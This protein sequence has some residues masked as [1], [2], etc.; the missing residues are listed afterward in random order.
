MCFLFQLFV[1]LIVTKM[2]SYSVFEIFVP[3]MKANFPQTKLT[4]TSSVYLF[5]L[6][7]KHSSSICEVPIP[8]LILTFL[9]V[10]LLSSCYRFLSYWKYF[11]MMREILMLNWLL[12]R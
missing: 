5:E 7:Q 10:L 1:P 12:L 3:E 2:P 8:F 11:K 6:V 4:L 9:C